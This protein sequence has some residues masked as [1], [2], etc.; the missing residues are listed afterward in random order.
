MRTR[1]IIVRVLPS[2]PALGAGICIICSRESQGVPA[3]SSI[4][5]PRTNHPIGE[6][7]PPRIAVTEILAIGSAFVPIIGPYIFVDLR[8]GMQDRIRN[9]MRDYVA[10]RA[11]VPMESLNLIGGNMS[12]VPMVIKISPAIS[13]LGVLDGINSGR[14]IHFC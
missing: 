8:I 12:S 7:D 1:N 9:T 6:A 11:R 14:L 4:G 13:I 3:V 2:S 5:T 10:S